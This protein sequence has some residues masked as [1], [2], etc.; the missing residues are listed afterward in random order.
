MFYCINSDCK[1]SAV[2][3]WFHYCSKMVF[4]SPETSL[5]S[6]V[7]G[8]VLIALSSTGLMFFTGNVLGISGILGSTI[9][10]KESFRSWRVPFLVGML[11]AGIVATVVAP[12]SAEVFFAS[13]HG[14]L[15]PAAA[16][17]AGVLV[18]FGTRMANGC[19]SG[20]G[21]CGL[22]RFSPRSLVAVGSFMAS[23]AVTAYFTRALPALRALIEV[24][25]RLQIAVGWPRSLSQPL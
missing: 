3:L 14:S 4:V 9:S 25:R 1:Y 17:L 19:T 8:G 18:G 13:K 20:H 15:K 23:G 12:G 24:R 5:A 11:G 10:K 21:V 2:V 7:G 16:A 22:P 6:G